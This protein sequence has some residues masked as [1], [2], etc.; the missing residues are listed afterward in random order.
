MNIKTLITRQ[1]VF[2]YFILVYLLVWGGILLIVR[3]LASASGVDPNTQVALVALPMLFAPGLVGIG[4]SAL[5]E[6]RAGLR[7][8]LARM[9]HWQVGGRWYVMALAVMPLLVLAILYAF[10][11]FISPRFAPVVSLFGLAGLAA[12]FFEEI[13]WTGFAVPRLLQRWRPLTVGLVVGLL[14]GL[15]HGLADYVIRGTTLGA[16][17]PITFSLFVL[18]LTAWRILMVWVYAN[19]QSGVV[20]QLMHF[21]YTGSLALF[22]PLAA[23]SYTEDALIYAVLAG[24]L[25]LLVAIVVIHQPRAQRAPQTT[26]MSG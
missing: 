24:G 10:A 17:W 13:G 12:G 7:A 20:A 18:P 25:W 9:T 23:I 3:M 2:T 6:G 11:F 16:F 19:T 21:A 15:W 14:W 5:V 8:M 26:S 4:V 22:V 1:P